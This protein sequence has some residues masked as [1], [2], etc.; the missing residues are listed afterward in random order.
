MDE[1]KILWIKAFNKKETEELWKQG[2]DLDDWDYALVIP[3]SALRKESNE[4]LEYGT[5]RLLT[6]CCENKWYRVLFRGK[7]VGMGVAYHS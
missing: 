1:L 6:G 3:E 5:D 2:V 4:P 7:K